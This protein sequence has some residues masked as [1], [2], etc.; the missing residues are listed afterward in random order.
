MPGLLS[1]WWFADFLSFDDKRKL[2]FYFVNL[3]KVL[4][5]RYVVIIAVTTRAISSGDSNGYLPDS[6]NPV[7][8]KIINSLQDPPL[9][10]SCVT[11]RNSFIIAFLLR[12]SHRRTELI[13]AYSG[14]TRRKPL[15]S[16]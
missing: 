12:N 2:R 15:L 14:D 8:A 6:S 13:T 3:I 10:T 5:F 7:W 4:D 16:L 1:I 9:S 11:H